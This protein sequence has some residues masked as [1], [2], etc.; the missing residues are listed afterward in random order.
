MSEST[1]LAPLDMPT[2]DAWAAFVRDRVDQDLAQA[3][4][5]LDTLKDGTARS[6]ADTLELW[7]DADIRLRNAGSLAGVL[8]QVHPDEEVRTLA[9]DREQQISRFD[10]DRGL[11]RALYEVLAAVEP[12]GLDEQAARLLERTLRDFRRSGVDRSEEVRDRLRDLAE[13]ATVVARS[14]PATSATTSGSIRIAPERLAGL[15][16]DFIDGHP[17]VTTGWSRSPP[18]TP[19]SS[20]S[21]PSPTT[22]RPAVSCS[23]SSRTGPGRRT[24]CCSPNCST[25]AQSRQSCSASTAGRTSTPR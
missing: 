10:T 21:G 8:A 25:C 18:T 12:T 14:S 1:K 17:S 13:R 15:P 24:T 19:T 6:A 9:E 3:R 7:N 2:G 5:L 11:D 16:Q 4:A 20:R 22:P 23:P